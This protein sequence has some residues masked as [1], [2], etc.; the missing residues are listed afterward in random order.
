MKSELGK[1]ITSGQR[2][3]LV[4]IGGVS[5]S[6]LARVLI[7]M[8]APITGSDINDSKAVKELRDLGVKVYIGHYPENVEGAGYIIR[9]AAAHD[10]NPEI[11][12]AR[13]Q[14]IPV[15]ER[16]EAWG[17]IMQSY[18]NAVCIS[19]THGKT[20]TT[21]MVTHVLME[22]QL[23][24]TVMIGGT[25]PLLHAGYRIGGG[26]T[27]V[28]ESCEYYNSFHKFY[29][30][31][32]AVLN[33]EEDHLDFFR[34]IEEIK[35][36]FRTFASLVPENGTVIA[37][38]DDKNTMDAL[39]GIDRNLITFGVENDAD[40]TA[41]NINMSAVHTDFDVYYRGEFYAH[42]VLHIPG[43]HN[44]KN[45][46]AAAAVAITLGIPAKAVETGLEKFGGAERRFQYKGEYNGA[47]VYDDYAHHPSE[48]HAL[49]DAVMSLG[50]RR[51]LLAFQPHTYTRTK[52][53]FDDFLSELKRPDKV[54]LAE[55]YAAREKNTIGISS[56]DLA[57]LIDNA[58][59]FSTLDELA[60]QLKK[61][62]G[63]GDIILT[64]GAGDIYKVGEAIVK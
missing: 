57:V 34:D 38:A 25:L 13:E 26:D 44:V 12:A 32:A 7:G 61:D 15:F 31:I 10:D 21:S 37:N 49:L 18:K 23:D 63:E 43:I 62:A 39:A 55:I 1:Y 22:A 27:I 20:T 16:A 60:E 29:P 9:T 42:P 19:G 5:M 4:G 58:E 2:G 35:A 52:A 59:Y 11:R 36:S 56:N 28:L 45:A 48:L 24:P 51:V 30:T 50:Y 17:Y 14:G 40:V 8:G 6:P 41:K 3:H 47:R 54:Y 46:L 64:V 33:V 53:L